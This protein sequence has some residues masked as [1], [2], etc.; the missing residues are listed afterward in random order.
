M[1][2]FYLEN[3]ELL[4]SLSKY[5]YER[6]G[7]SSVDLGYPTNSAIFE[8]VKSEKLPFLIV[9]KPLRANKM[10]VPES[11]KIRP[12]DRAEGHFKLSPIET[13]GEIITNRDLGKKISNFQFF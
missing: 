2:F 11:L 5:Y 1:K 8:T 4:T 9:K 12:T 6:C 7:V 13:W 3:F 10:F